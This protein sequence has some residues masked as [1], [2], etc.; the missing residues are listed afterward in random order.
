ME[1]PTIVIPPIQK[2]KTVEI[3]LPTADVPYYVPLVVPPSDLKE[4]EGTKPIE[5][6]E[7]PVTPTLN[8]PPLPPIPI[9]P[10]DVLIT[11]SVA[12]VTAVAATTVTQ[13][14]IQKVKEKIQKFLNDKIK[15]WKEKFLNRKKKKKDSSVN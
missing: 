7:T 10:T 2:I 5:T 12:A 11:T 14:I 13:P 4:P 8:L 15:T 3:P 6:T 9:P 1:I